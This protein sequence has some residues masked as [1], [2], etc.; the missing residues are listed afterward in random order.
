MT[1]IQAFDLPL[2]IGLTA[3]IPVMSTRI[4]TLARPRSAGCRTMAWQPR[5][6][7]SCSLA[8]TLMWAIS[9]ASVQRA[10]HDQRPRVPPQTFRWPCG[11]SSGCGHGP[12]FCD[13]AAAGAHSAL[14]E[15]VSFL[16]GSFLDQ[17]F[18]S[19]R[20]Y[21][22]ILEEPV[23]HRAFFNTVL[24]ISERDIVIVLSLLVSWFCCA[25][26]VRSASG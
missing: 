4:Y 17:M 20:A 5:S 9:A 14:G 6:E 21:S 2:V 3:Q 26:R 24:L 11:E 7:S 13:H 15:P 1:M 23:V 10:G 19:L 12:L 16:S 18:G 22:K 25:A 8:M